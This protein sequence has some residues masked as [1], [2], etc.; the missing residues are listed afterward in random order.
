MPD[1]WRP[2]LRELVAQ[3]RHWLA[4]QQRLGLRAVPGKLL[5]EKRLHET[6][7]SELATL[8][9]S[10][11]TLAAVRDELGDCQRCKLSRFRS[12]IVFGDGSPQARLVL[13]GEAPG[14]EEDRQGLPFVGA[15]GNLLDRLLKKLGLNRGELYI[16]NIVKCRP[17]G[18]RN[19]EADEIN[20]CLP[21]LKK[22]LQV[23]RPRIICLL[24]RIATQ[25]LL[26][27]S[28]P[29]NKLRGQWQEW[30]GI[31]VMPT[32]HP[33]YLLRFPEQRKKTWEDMQKVMELYRSAENAS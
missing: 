10:K 3:L 33:S 30:Q 15:A 6:K 2:E 23:I 32:Y 25:V 21:F 29:L 27:T 26:E 22:Q 16:T 8:D 24:G 7:K 18:N 20:S 5:T 14:E 13:V 11:L 4:Y 28:T 31:K 9:A 12:H 19:P 1:P 17:P